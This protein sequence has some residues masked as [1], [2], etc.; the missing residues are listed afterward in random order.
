MIRHL[1]CCGADQCFFAAAAG[2]FRIGNGSP[3][4]D[5]G[6]NANYPVT[7][8]AVDLAGQ[9]QLQLIDSVGMRLYLA[10]FLKVC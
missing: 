1:R 9:P 7:A 2:D 5:L 6:A 3:Y 10:A 4:T 8:P